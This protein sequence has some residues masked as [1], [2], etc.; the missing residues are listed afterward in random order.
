MPIDHFFQSLAEQEKERAIGV[1]LSGSGTDGTVGLRAIKDEGGLTLAEADTTAK[2]FAMPNSAIV[3]GCVDVIRSAKDIALEIE[4]IA[5]HP[6]VRGKPAADGEEVKF[7]GFPEGADALTKVFYLIKQ[8]TGVNFAEYKHSTLRRRIAR[9]MIL[10][11]LETLDDYV[12]LLRSDANEVE[13]LF[14]DILINVTSFFRDPAAFATLQKKILPKIIK[15]KAPRGDIR[16]WVPGCSTGEEVY[17]V[18]IAVMETLGQHV[19]VF[20]CRSSAQ[21]SANRSSPRRGPEFTPESIAKGV[22]STRLR[23]FFTKTPNG[24]YQISRSIRDMCTFARQNVCEDPP[25]SHIDLITCRNVLI[26]LGPPL[27]KKCIP[28]FHYALNPDGYLM[29]GTS[30]SVGGFADLFALVDK[31]H[32]I[33]VKK[34][35]GLAPGSRLSVP[36]ELTNLSSRTVQHAASMPS[37]PEPGSELQKQ[38]DRLILTRYSPNA[39][40]IDEG[41]QVLQF[42]GATSRFLE[43]A[44]GS[45]FAESSPDGS[46]AIDHRFADRSSS[47]AQGERGDSA[48]EYLPQGQRGRAPREH[49]G[50]PVSNLKERSNVFCW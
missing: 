40:V 34:A 30:E 21:I 35:T 4:T 19:T 9:R 22:S 50:D 32:K 6:Y 25:F 13:Q 10:M 1:V 45:R 11:Q 28:V 20:G 36:T 44:S 43:H 2:Y 37:E 7:S 8:H 33:Y 38:V 14:N 39:V 17:S 41:M 27:Q 47:S 26:Y 5:R 49:R 31:K 15:A 48:R 16:I 12:S 24:D 18:A 42:R 29:L 3:A 23:R 46:A